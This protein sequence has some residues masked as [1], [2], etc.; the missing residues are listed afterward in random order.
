MNFMKPKSTLRPC[1]LILCVLAV[2]Q[3]TFA[4]DHDDDNKR[5]RSYQKGHHD[6]RERQTYV[7]R[8]R[9]SFS[10]SLGTG[11]A[12]RGY[13]YGPSGSSYYYERPEVHYYATREAAPHEYYS[14]RASPDAAVQNALAQRG[15]YRGP[16]DGQIGPQSRNAIARYQ[17]NQGMRP[18]GI[19]GDSL[20][21]SLGL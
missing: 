14:T 11:Y 5:G 12:G 9:S 17:S 16:I 8:P 15:Y 6:D 18:T 10:L 20:I 19:I 4:K 2:H 3:A 1:L 7:S 21:R 13:Y